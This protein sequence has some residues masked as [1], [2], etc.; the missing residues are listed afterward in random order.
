MSAAAAARG[1]LAAAA[2]LAVLV[3]GALPASAHTELLGVVP[4]PGAVV[5]GGAQLTV[6]LTFSEAVDPALAAVVVVDSAERVVAADAPRVDGAAVNQVVRGLSAGEY[7][8]RYRVVS[9]DGHPVDGES[10]FS[11]AAAPPPAT[12]APAREPSTAA[13]ANPS[14]TGSA[15]TAP[16]AETAPVALTS[17]PGDPDG[18]SALPLGLGAALL[19]LTAVG[20]GALMA[21]RRRTDQR[22]PGVDD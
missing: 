19:L 2:A 17:D 12:A 3:L 8:I 15:S 18:A 21:R 13:S 14:G 5:A 16:S 6:T 22:G 7:A 4:G 11:V 1:A 20:G 10:R 9:A